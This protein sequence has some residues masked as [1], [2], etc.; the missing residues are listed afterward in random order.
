[1]TLRSFRIGHLHEPHSLG[2]PEKAFGEALIERAVVLEPDNQ[3]WHHYNQS[4]L[5]S[6]A[7]MSNVLQMNSGSSSPRSFGRTNGS[8]DA[9]RA[10]VAA[11]TGDPHFYALSDLVKQAVRESKFDDAKA[12]AKEMLGT[13]AKAPDNQLNGRAPGWKV[14]CYHA[15]ST[16]KE[17]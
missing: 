12:I 6:R 11:M 13:A 14:E 8:F 7:A 5:N 1:M 3:T 17:P 10:N 9:M 16:P 4:V 2:E 15:R